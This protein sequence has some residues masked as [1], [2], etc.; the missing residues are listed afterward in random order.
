MKVV[1]RLALSSLLLI[2]TVLP[3]AA[4]DPFYA[5]YPDQPDSMQSISDP[6][7]TL[8]TY[9]KNFGAYLGYDLAQ[10]G[11]KI[12]SRQLLNPAVMQ[13]AQNYLFNA[14]LGARPVNT[15]STELS[16]FVADNSAYSSYTPIN[17]FANYTFK[18]PPYN[19]VSTQQGN[20]SVTPLIDQQTYQQDPVSQEILNILAT[21]DVT[22]CMNNDAT[23]LLPQ[24]SQC[25]PLYRDK[26]MS[27]V[28]GEPLPNTNQYFTYSYIQKFLPQLNGNSL[29]APL[30]YS[31]EGTEATTSSSPTTSKDQ[32]LTAENQAQTAANFIRYAS[33]AVNPLALPKKATYDRLYSTVISNPNPADSQAVLAQ[34]QAQATLANYFTSLRAYAAQ[35]SVGVSNL[36]YVLS[37]RMPQNQSTSEADPKPTSQAMSE[38]V[39]A[40]WR[41]YNPDQ[42]QNPDQQWIQQINRASPETVQKEIATL[43]AEINYQL[44]LNRQQEERI[45]L[46]NTML[47][48]Q[49]LNNF[50]PTLSPESQQGA[51]TN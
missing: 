49:S 21:P 31:T 4:D 48:M 5:A 46:T 3:A 30:I 6:L 20:V 51:S 16:K 50:Q 25:P 39:M 2:G 36:Y 34:Q 13:V 18:K 41:L 7:H 23:A 19:T 8:V 9:L 38:F 1:S 43:L 45:L 44:Y 29:M 47:L 32:G 12:E 26:V 40:N 17:A 10:T 27:N 28:L 37:K 35:K 15:F 11:V 22:Y 33:G 24:G 14:F 42:A